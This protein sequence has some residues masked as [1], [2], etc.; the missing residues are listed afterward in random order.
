ME[1]GGGGG[2]GGAK[3]YVHTAQRTKFLT[4]MVEGLLKFPGVLDA[5]SC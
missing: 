1:W 4:A 2:G 3:A 5:L